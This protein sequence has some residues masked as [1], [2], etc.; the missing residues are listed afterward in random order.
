[1]RRDV[2]QSAPEVLAL[3]HALL[4]ADQV[5]T[6][7]L[8]LQELMQGFAGPKDRA[9]LVERLSALAFLQPVKDDHLEAAEVR[10]AC[11]RRGVPIGTMDA[12]LIQL[13]LRNDL[14]LL[15]TD[16]DFHSAAKHVAFSLWGAS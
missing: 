16:Q 13:C 3:R 10:N 14:T 4:G 15:T 5:F 6:T 7:G 11:R 1:L 9:Q 8:V 12:L 2:E